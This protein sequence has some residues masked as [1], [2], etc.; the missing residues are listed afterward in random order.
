MTVALDVLFTW[1]CL[2]CANAR[3]CCWTELPL[4][5]LLVKVTPPGQSDG[6]LVAHLCVL[7]IVSPE[8]EIKNRVLGWPGSFLWAS[9]VC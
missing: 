9:P 1:M 8:G 4:L 3:Q 6:L 5:L 2:T 7:L